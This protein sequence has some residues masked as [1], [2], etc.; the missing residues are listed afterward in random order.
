[1]KRILAILLVIVTCMALVTSAMAAGTNEITYTFAKMKV[2]QTEYTTKGGYTL[3]LDNPVHS[4][5]SDFDESRYEVHFYSDRIINPS[6]GQNEHYF[7]KEYTTFQV[8]DANGSDAYDKVYFFGPLLG[9]GISGNTWKF[10]KS[11][12]TGKLSMYL[13]YN[14]VGIKEGP[15]E[16]TIFRFISSTTGDW[17][18]PKEPG[19]TATGTKPNF[20]DVPANAFYKEA[21]DWAVANGITNGT[22]ATTFSPD[23]TCTHGEIQTLIWRACGSP[24]FD[25]NGNLVTQ[26]D[27]AHTKLANAWMANRK[28]M[29]G[30]QIPYYENENSPCNRMA[31]VRYFWYLAGDPMPTT[32]SAFIDLPYLGSIEGN[33]DIHWA[34]EQGI[35]KGTSAT[36]FSP[37]KTC[38][39]GEI[40]TFLYR[41]FNK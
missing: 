28:Y 16:Y 21:V 20:T 14:Y 41:Y 35:T 34:V 5:A 19:T 8:T 17:D 23:K 33:P 3:K 40:V 4:V 26:L 25:I 13:G 27:E 11:T 7:V 32:K 31:V 10:E 37:L 24:E 6:V 1:M 2:G 30:W 29:L 39:R 9:L 15:T 22:S 36:T 12:L 18:V 38:T